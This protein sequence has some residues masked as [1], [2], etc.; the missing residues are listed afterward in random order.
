MT[1]SS[2]RMS[3]SVGSPFTKEIVE[4]FSTGSRSPEEV[5]ARLDEFGIS[6]HITDEGDLVIRYWQV[7]AEDFVPKEH[8]ARIRASRSAPAEA[9]S[10]EWVSRHMEELKA[11]YGGQWVAIAGGEVVAFSPTVQGLIETLQEAGVQGPFITQ[12]PAEPVVWR[13]AY[14]QQVL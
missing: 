5:L 8:V 2:A 10:L 9:D 3:S 4:S 12:I 1:V 7:V 11:R 14:G 13:S 6:W